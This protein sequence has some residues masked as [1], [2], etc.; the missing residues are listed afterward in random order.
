MACNQR[1][2]RP[3]SASPRPSVM[4]PC[5]QEAATSSVARE[6][7]GPPAPT[8][9]S[10]RSRGTRSKTEDSL[11]VP[12]LQHAIT[13]Q[14]VRFYSWHFPSR[15]YFSTFPKA[16]SV[17]SFQM[18]M[19][20]HL[21]DACFQVVRAWLEDLCVCANSNLRGSRTASSGASCTI[22]PSA[23]SSSGRLARA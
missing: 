23:E 11:G 15:T 17:H 7:E 9:T 19:S 3:A 5:Q 14:I 18:A 22:N 16:S 8:A 6:S 10:A 1:R 2:C 13:K 21:L 20:T 12:Q 4:R